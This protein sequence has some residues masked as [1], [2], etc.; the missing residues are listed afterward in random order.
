MSLKVWERLTGQV[1]N[2][3]VGMLVFSHLVSFAKLLELLFG[4]FVIRIFVRVVS[5]GQFSVRPLYFLVASILFDPKNLVIVLPARLLEFKL[6]P[7]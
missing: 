2:S 5:D 1:L 4:M 3:E 7:A 6:S